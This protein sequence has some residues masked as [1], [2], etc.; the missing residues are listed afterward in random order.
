MPAGLRPTGPGYMSS[1][2]Q[3]IGS[4]IEK[5]KDAGAPAPDGVGHQAGGF[6]S[7]QALEDLAQGMAGMGIGQEVGLGQAVFD[8]ID[9]HLSIGLHSPPL[10]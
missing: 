2:L 3:I 1:R 4:A 6:I 7:C 9:Q 10:S 5:G 8:V